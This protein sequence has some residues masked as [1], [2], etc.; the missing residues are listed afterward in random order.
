MNNIIEK[1]GRTYL[2]ETEI[3]GRTLPHAVS[4]IRDDTGNPLYT[5]D[6]DANGNMIAA[7][8]QSKITIRAKGTGVADNAPE[9]E[10][11][12][13]GKKQTGWTVT[14]TE[15]KEYTWYGYWDTTSLIDIVFTNDNSSGGQE[16]DLFIDW[17]E[18]NGVRKQSDESNVEYD[19]GYYS[20]G[21][22][23]GTDV[24][25]GQEQMDV[26]GALR[27]AF[28]GILALDRTI[29]YDYENRM[30]E[31]ID[32]GTTATFAYNARGHRIMKTVNGITTV[33]YTH[34]TLP[35]N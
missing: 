31:V 8:G 2:Y 14:D 30:I 29:S 6:Y 27:F 34:L 5:Y 7:H 9:M 4:E 35:T 25:P 11:W 13:D 32:G 22:F 17:V 19:R 23:D 16:T 18:V 1:D 21:C 24:V 28:I 26:T 3:A 12:L 10:L 15:Y 20:G 33:S